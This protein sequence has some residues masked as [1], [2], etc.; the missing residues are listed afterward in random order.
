MRASLPRPGY[1]LY[2]GQEILETLVR[3]VLAGGIRLYR[4]KIVGRDTLNFRSNS[5]LY[6]GCVVVMSV[7]VCATIRRPVV[8]TSVSVFNAFCFCRAV[9]V[10][11]YQSH[12]RG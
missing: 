6:A 10:L 4:G 9:A 7:F 5:R 2:D 11:T 1:P 3:R 12:L 8:M